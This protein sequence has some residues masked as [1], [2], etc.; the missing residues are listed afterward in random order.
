MLPRQISVSRLLAVLGLVALGGCNVVPP[1][2]SDTTR[3]FLL[4]VP[5]VVEKE[6]PATTGTLLLGLKPVGVAPYLRKGSLVVRVGDNEVLFPNDARWAEPLEQE[7]TVLLRKGL[8][9]APSVARVL[10]PPFPFEAARDFDVSVQVL[11]CEGVREG[12]KTVARLV[13]SLEIFTPGDNPQLLARKTIAVP[14]A[15][16]DGKDFARLAALL[17][18]AVGV[19]GREIAAALPEKKG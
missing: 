5:A 16:W 3:N 13:A 15:A 4:S 12:G 6:A 10:V 19:L 17:G 2:Q 14:D 8:Q 9:A 11:Q 18:E 7:I 1:V